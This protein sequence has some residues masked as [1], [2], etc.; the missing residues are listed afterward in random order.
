MKI[1]YK[2][3]LS[4]NKSKVVEGYALSGFFAAHRVATGWKV[5]HMKSGYALVDPAFESQETAKSFVN[6]I[7]SAFD[8]ELGFT[9]Q[10]MPQS[11]GILQD[12]IR[13]ILKQIAIDQPEIITAE[14]LA[15][16]GE[17]NG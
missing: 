11:P 7:E 2:I 12:H 15:G 5:T 14:Y 6:L 8:K 17:Q 16:L 4:G 1:N 3:T 9:D 13:F 10:H